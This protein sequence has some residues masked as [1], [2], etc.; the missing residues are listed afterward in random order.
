MI[1]IILDASAVLALVNREPGAERVA[2]RL[3]NGAISAVNVAEVFARLDD[4]G[5]DGNMCRR[6]IAALGLQII[7]FDEEDAAASGTLRAETRSHGLSLGDRAC[8]GLAK[9]M[10][11]PALTADRAWGNLS[12]GVDVVM[13]R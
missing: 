4:I 5:L 6:V 9:R 13:I 2:T 8:L 7:P 12:L 1:D 3:A 10:G 11:V